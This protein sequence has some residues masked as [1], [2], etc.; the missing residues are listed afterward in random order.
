[1]GAITA[2]SGQ[3]ILLVS[4]GDDCQ[5]Y[6]DCKAFW[7]GVAAFATL[8]GDAPLLAAAVAMVAYNDF[9]IGRACRTS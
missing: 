6:T 7:E 4:G 5:V 2:L 9:L 3:E 1:M 8:T